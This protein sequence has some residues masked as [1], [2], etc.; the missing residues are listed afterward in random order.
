MKL[1][2]NIVRAIVCLIV[3][4]VTNNQVKAGIDLRSPDNKLHVKVWLYKGCLQY[5]VAKN[6]LLLIDSSNLGIMLD[7]K[8]HGEHIQDLR[9]LQQ[10]QLHDTVAD[11][12]IKK[13]LTCYEYVLSVK[14]NTTSSIEFRVYNDGCAFRYI[15]NGT[16]L[17]NGESSSF[18]LPAQS[19]VWFFERDSDWKLKSYA[20]WWKHT[21]VDSL[22][23]ISKQGPIQGKPLV[24]QLRNKGYMVLTEAAL[25]N[26]SGMRYKAIGN[27][28]V[29][30]NFTE[31]DKGFTVQDKVVTPWRVILYNTSLDA[32]VNN[33]LIAALNPHPNGLLFKDITYIKPGKA[34]WSWITRKA[35]FMQPEEEKR[36][37]DAAAQL[38]FQYTLLDEGWETIWPNKWQQLKDIVAYGN[39][40]GIGVWVWKHSKELMNVEQ[41][42][43]F[44]DSVVA[45][46][47]VG[48]K[49][50]FMN[51][52]A[53]P[54][55]DFEIGLLEAAA[56]HKL[57]VNFHG[58]HTATGESITYPNE[59]TREGIRGMELNGMKEPIPAW[60]NA[61]LPFTRL[62]CGHG[63]YTP[64]WFSNKGNTTLAHQLALFY[65]FNSPFQCM[66]ENPVTLLQT[67]AY[68]PLVSWLQE[69]PVTWDETIVLQ[70][71]EIGKLAA[72]AKRKGDV[73]YVSVINGEA[74]AKPYSLQLP[75]VKS[76][77]TYTISTI[78]DADDGKSLTSK[79]VTI[80]TLMQP[81][82][83][84]PNGGLVVRFTPQR[85]TL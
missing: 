26:Y 46:G 85:K 47:V 48:I 31:G 68:Q 60:H 37:I 43:A 69:L 21:I 82:M 5:A 73:W 13:Y 27:N 23:V 10:S 24:V 75:F 71:S 62:L 6:D 84:R 57:M 67:Q 9:L 8:N 65:L 18:Q 34:V 52:E 59:M 14:G 50:D 83:L 79:D 2:N 36:F 25:Y 4:L 1:A 63:D 22:P 51:S 61:A 49:T 15:V 17:V 41:R 56:Q 70:G 78:T 3:L 33:S 16:H 64:G 7:G 54:Y 19:R 30:A 80:N 66:A 12:S 74:V 28:T 35:N 29:Q 44:L 77:H 72:M 20:G 81:Q 53:K 32:L 38:R 40:K 76:T 45:C 58:C 55:I 42:N 39:S 11:R